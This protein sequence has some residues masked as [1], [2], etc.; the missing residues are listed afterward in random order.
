MANKKTAPTQFQVF[1]A[2]SIACIGLYSVFY[3]KS[4][5]VIHQFM[6]E[7]GS[8]GVALAGFALLI[9]AS[10]SGA[11]AIFCESIKLKTAFLTGLSFPGLLF[12]AGLGLGNSPSHRI[13]TPTSMIRPV[14]DSSTILVAAAVAPR[15]GTFQAAFS[16]V[17]NPAGTILD[18]SRQEAQILSD[19][20]QAAEKT[21]DELAASKL[22]IAQ[23]AT[24]LQIE[25]K[26]I[27]AQYQ[28]TDQTAK[29]FIEALSYQ[30]DKCDPPH[31]TT[32]DYRLL[33][34]QGDVQVRDPGS[35]T[36]HP[37]REGDAL[38]EGTQVR[39]GPNARAIVEIKGTRF[40]INRSTTFTVE[41][42]QN[43]LQFHSPKGVPVYSFPR[44][45]PDNYRIRM[46]NGVEGIR[47]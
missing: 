5:P 20:L 29:T 22:R 15:P 31:A 19:K 40:L 1:L 47:G 39:T 7:Y 36:W 3:L 16:L 44:D 45:K 13:H 35:E 23:Q 18:A 4:Y 43:N 27:D 8:S 37:A 9:V 14:I 2:G 38:R 42:A 46:P 30:I 25:I 32:N 26:R 11:W 17:F 21:A 10:L 12:G 34:A 41:A 24:N 33:S 28:Q 6:H